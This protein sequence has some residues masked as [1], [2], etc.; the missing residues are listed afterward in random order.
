MGSAI[1]MQNS[2]I[3]VIRSKG[4]QFISSLPSELRRCAA[5][6][7]LERLR[8]CAGFGVAHRSP[9]FGYRGVGLDEQPGCFLHALSCDVAGWGHPCRRLEEGFQFRRPYVELFCK[10]GTGK[11]P[12]KVG[13]DIPA[14]EINGS[15]VFVRQALGAVLFGVQRGMLH[16]GCDGF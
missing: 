11:V 16:D 15:A 14:D 13:G 4:V 3:P 2:S 1:S 7:S 12:L 9:D 5:L 10:T 8:E 6:V